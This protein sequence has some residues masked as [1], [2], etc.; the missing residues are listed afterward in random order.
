MTEITRMTEPDSLPFVLTADDVAG[1]CGVDRKTIYA[2]CKDMNSD[3]PHNR[4][5]T[6]YVFHRDAVL[7][8]LRGRGGVSRS[9]RRRR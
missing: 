7:E 8:W 2:F 4:I 5:G 6:R 9:S 3:L 1:L